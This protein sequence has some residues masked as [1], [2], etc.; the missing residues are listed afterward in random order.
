MRIIQAVERLK[1]ADNVDS[2]ADTCGMQW[3]FVRRKKLGII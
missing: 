2:P 1:I 3:Q